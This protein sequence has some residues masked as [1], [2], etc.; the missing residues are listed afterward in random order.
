MSEADIIPTICVKSV[1]VYRD[2]DTQL[3][4]KIMAE[5]QPAILKECNFGDCFAKWT[6]DYLTEVF[7]DETIVI[8]E[9]DEAELDFIGKNFKYRTVKFAEFAK[10]LTD[11]NRKGSVY[12]RSINKDPRSKCPASIAIDFPA[13]KDDLKPPSFVPYGDENE[14]YHSSVLRIASNNVQIWTHFDLYDNVL[15][16]VIGHKRVTLFPPGDIRFLYIVGDKSPVNEFD[17]WKKCINK[18]PMVAMASPYACVLDP[19]DV[20]FIPSLWW[21]NVR[22]FAKKSSSDFGYS[23]GFNIFWKDSKINNGL[24]YAKNDVYGNKNLTLFDAALTN[25]DKAL[26][27]LDKLPEKYKEF[28]KIMLFERLKAK[29][30]Q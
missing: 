22:T 14:L 12:L 25:L 2:V 8:H 21:H 5:D 16:Q 17:D 30:F 10:M 7:K 13:I 4:I 19:G 23:I 3:F 11:T 24:T 9:S 20:L 26:G 18:Y 27:H 6:L 29:I 28:F 1:K 15:C